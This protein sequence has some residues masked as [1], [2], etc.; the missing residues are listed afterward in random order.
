MDTDILIENKDCFY[1]KRC[2]NSCKL[3]ILFR[4]IWLVKTMCGTH[5]IDPARRGVKADTILCNFVKLQP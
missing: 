3:R 4:M 1:G 2:N 5:V